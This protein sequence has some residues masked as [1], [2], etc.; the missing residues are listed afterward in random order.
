[1]NVKY[2][3]RTLDNLLQTKLK[4][5]DEATDTFDSNHEFYW[6]GKAGDKLSHHMVPLAYHYMYLYDFDFYSYVDIGAA[7]CPNVYIKT[8]DKCYLFEPDDGEHLALI[9]K[10]TNNSD[11]KLYDEFIDDMN[12]LD[13]YN[14]S[15][16]LLKID[17]D[18]NDGKVI[19]GSEITL[20]REKP[21]VFVEDLTNQTEA[22]ECLKDNNFIEVSGKTYSNKFYVHSERL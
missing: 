20:V 22:L 1:M 14:L 4:S 11:V 8:F 9:D 12:T 5:Y 3:I 13:G 10:F 21:L 2:N 19:I 17:T 16:D 15:C 18:G 6:G 7:R